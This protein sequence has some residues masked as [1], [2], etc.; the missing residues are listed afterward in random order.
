MSGRL[1]QWKGE[2]IMR[3]L[4]AFLVLSVA[5]PISARVTKALAPPPAGITLPVVI[6]RNLKPRNLQEGQWLTAELVQVVPVSANVSL[7]R[8]A[9]LDGHV[10]S[11]SGSTISIL[12]D[13]LSWK[14]RT[15]SVHVRLIAAAASN[16]VLE[17]RV[18]LGGTERSTSCEADWTTKQVGGD[19]VYLSAGSGKVYDRYSQPV[20]YADFS[21]VYADPSAQGELPRAMG[22]FSTTVT[23]LHGF[24]GFSIVSPGGVNTPITLTAAKPN[25]QIERGS[26]WLLEVL[27]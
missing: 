14:G 15:L 20:G 9:K 11:V 18:P 12:F 8:G 13:Q 16:E 23:G 19:E 5:V 17:T 3:Y 25:W 21:G 26:A 6:Q 10:V 1:R 2:K 22:P 27:E 24:L 4:I 7:P